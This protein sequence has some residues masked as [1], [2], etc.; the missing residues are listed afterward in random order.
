LRWVLEVQARFSDI[1]GTGLASALTLTLFLSLFPLLLVAA[2]V[3]GFLQA[4]GT[5]VAGRVIGELG[6]TGTAAETV[7]ESVGKAAQSR[8]ATSIIGV[9]GLLWS[10][11]GLGAGV[12]QA[13]NSVWKVEGRGIKD[14]AIGLAWI[15]GAAILFVGSTAVTAAVGWLPDGLAPIALVGSFAASF[16]LWVWTLKW[17]PNLRLGF[18][19]VLPGAIVGA[20]GLEALKLIGAV[21]VPRAVAS[22]SQMYGT[23]GVVFAILAWLLVFGRL[24]VYSGVVCVVARDKRLA[25]RAPSRPQT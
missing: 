2:A 23:L 14:K 20:I 25:K 19:D 6:L 3:A 11:L 13:L 16:G 24:V 1:H 9:V 5:D 8:R 7:Q 12:Q 10:G 17:L 22:S 21:W 4:K 15:G 18:R